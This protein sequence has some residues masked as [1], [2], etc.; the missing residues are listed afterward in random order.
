MGRPGFLTYHWP[1]GNEGMEKE[2]GNYYTGLHR[3]YYKDSFLHS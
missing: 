1:A 2:N 3:D